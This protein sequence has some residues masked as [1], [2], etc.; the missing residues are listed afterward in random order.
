MA[1]Q[2]RKCPTCQGARTT[3]GQTACTTC[4]GQGVVAQSTSNPQYLRTLYFYAL[5]DNTGNPLAGGAAIRGSM[6]IDARADFEA[7]WLVATSTGTFTTE[8][9]D[10]SGQPFQN[11]PVN[12]ANQ[13]GTIQLPFTL[14]VPIVM[15][16]KSS[17]TFTITDTSG[18]P[19]TIQAGFW[20][21]QLY[22][23]LDA[24]GN[25]IPVNT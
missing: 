9:F 19:N 23:P 13:W 17:I 24:A 8:M 15:P 11:V 21:Y 6:Q 1:M 20:G 2:F 5:L 25:P 12:N 18:G 7:I 16:M 10:K 3:N 22:P 4:N 14:P